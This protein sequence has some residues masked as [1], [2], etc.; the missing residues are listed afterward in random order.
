MAQQHKG[1]A[2]L[3]LLSSYGTAAQGQGGACR[4]QVGLA[5]QHKGKAMLSLSS[6]G[7]AAA[8]G[9]GGDVVVK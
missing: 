7:T 4:C 8:Q 6:Y 2:T 5:R 3:S 1:K 9:E